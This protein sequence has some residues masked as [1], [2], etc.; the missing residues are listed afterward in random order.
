MVGNMSVAL[1]IGD[2]EVMVRRS[3]KRHT[4]GLTIERDGQVVAAVP[5]NMSLK[6][7][8]E[9]VR[10]RETWVHSALLRRSAIAPASG[11]K[12]YVS[13]EGFHYLGRSYRL[14]VLRGTTGVSGLPELRLFEGTFQL[15]ADCVPRGR[16]CFVG[17]YTGQ[18]GTWLS[19]KLPQL[20]RRVGAIVRR[21]S[22]MDL[23][24]RWG[25]CSEAGR[26]NF[27]WRAILLPP[28]LVSYLVLHE[29]C[30]LLEHNHT[31]KFWALVRRVDHDFERKERWLRENGA[32]FS[33]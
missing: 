15:R 10:Q 30:H 11:S 26:V 31:E 18:M 19:E 23:G 20:Q 5:A 1:S 12:E 9:I 25:S 13:G 4:V 27:H 17:W 16:E 33:L 28:R 29:L 14:R 8:T 22:V 24:L 6:E 21:T 32:R 2:V 3:H 7:V